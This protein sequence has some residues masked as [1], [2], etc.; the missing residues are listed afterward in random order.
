MP[1]LP[2]IKG[3]VLQWSG[4]RLG[5]G[6]LLRREPIANAED[7]DS[8]E[9]DPSK[10]RRTAYTWQ[11]HV[12]DRLFGQHFPEVLKSKRDEIDGQYDNL[13]ANCMVCNEKT[14]YRCINCELHLCI[15]GS[16][17]DSDCFRKFHSERNF[18]AKK[19]SCKKK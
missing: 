17:G 1:L 14:P 13:R 7:D 5:G 10:R 4:W 18:G 12:D 6:S 3:V 16:R 2:F 11:K 15:M 19:H 9:E 8:E